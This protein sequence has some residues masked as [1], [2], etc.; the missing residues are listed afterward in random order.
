MPEARL[1]KSVIL[2][3]FNDAAIRPQPEPRPVKK[4]RVVCN[5][6]P[7]GQAWMKYNAIMSAI[8]E[9]RRIRDE[10]QRWLLGGSRDF[11]QVCHMAGWEPEYIMKLASALEK[12]RWFIPAKTKQL[13][14]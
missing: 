14:A 5:G 1:F 12:E 13:A 3:A 9:Q 2:Q 8:R 11:V 6:S 4:P 10:A 7:S